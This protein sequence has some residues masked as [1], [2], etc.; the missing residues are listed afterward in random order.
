[1]T[2]KR[3]RTQHG[4]AKRWAWRKVGLKPAEGF[5]QSSVQT[6][7][8]PSPGRA[9]SPRPWLRIELEK[10]LCSRHQSCGQK[11]VKWEMRTNSTSQGKQPAPNVLT[12][13][14]A[15]TDGYLGSPTPTTG[16]TEMQMSSIV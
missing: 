1:M 9:R 8:S 3:P 5:E 10:E 11:D 4:L 6:A 7:Q 13:P 15:A 2:T 14:W 16:S 12:A